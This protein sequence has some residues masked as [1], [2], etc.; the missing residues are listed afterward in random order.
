MSG[1]YLHIPF[2]KRACHYCNF[3]FS[4]SLKYKSDMVKAIIKEID[5]RKNEWEDET[6]NTIYFGGGTPSLLTISELD[7]IFDTLYQSFDLSS[8]IEIT[9]EANPDDLTKEK[10]KALSQSP[11]NRLSIGIQSFAEIDLRYMNRAHNAHEAHTC[12]ENALKAGYTN[13]TADL[14]YGTPGMSDMQWR[15][16]LHILFNLNI[17]H[18]S[19]YALT[20]EDNT[21]LAHFIK[22]GKTT[23]VDEVQTARQFEIL[24]QEMAANNYEHYE[25]SNFCKSGNYSKHNT[26][27]WQGEKYLG[28]GPAAHSFD[29]HSRSWNVANNAKYMTAIQAGKLPYEVEQLSDNDRFNEYI[30]TG[31]RTKWGCDLNKIHTH[32]DTFVQHFLQAVQPYLNNK[33]IIRKGDIFRLSNEGKLLSDGIISDLFIV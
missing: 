24:T 16:N 15:K 20:V 23:P 1:I 14:I 33:M 10:L 22:K 13:L 29:G 25:I 4:T 28:I 7:K 32:N 27:Y 19:C 21:A 30:L 18:V 2:C 31:L 5:L 12:L 26:A 6:I 11:V 17:P 8:N 3:H 9:L